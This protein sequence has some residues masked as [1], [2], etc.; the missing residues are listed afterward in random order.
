MYPQAIPEQ[1][2]PKQFATYAEA[3]ASL[4]SDA[5]WSSSFGDFVVGVDVYFRAGKARWSVSNRDPRFDAW[6]VKPV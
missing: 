1:V 3:V 4:P 6:V 2:Q 5:A